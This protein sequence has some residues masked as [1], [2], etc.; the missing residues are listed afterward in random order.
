MDGGRI[1]FRENMLDFITLKNQAVHDPELT[2]KVRNRAEIHARRG[3]AFFNACKDSYE[4]GLPVRLI[5]NAGIRRNGEDF[6][7]TSIVSFRELDQENWYVHRFNAHTGDCLIVR[8]VPMRQLAEDPPEPV[9]DD[10][11]PGADDIRRM[12][13][14]RVRQGQPKFRDTLLNAYGR[15]CAVTGTVILQILEAAHIVPHAQGTDYRVQNGLLLRAD[16]HTLFDQYLLSIDERIRVHLSHTLRNTEYWTSYH[17]KDMRLPR[18]SLHT[19]DFSA[20]QR[21]HLRFLEEERA[22]L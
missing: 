19:P 22:R 10:N 12:A 1:I 20:L 21:R 13:E 8:G 2:D 7:D 17:G 11:S 9:E 15:R 5:L 14:I 4:S 3:S 16:I 18:S 6:D